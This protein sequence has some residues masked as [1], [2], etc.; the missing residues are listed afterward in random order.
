MSARS[1]VG[2]TRHTQVSPHR[3]GWEAPP[4]PAP[5]EPF[6]VAAPLPGRVHQ[7]EHGND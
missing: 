5:H 7:G 1:G 4:P 2:D 6:G 3:A